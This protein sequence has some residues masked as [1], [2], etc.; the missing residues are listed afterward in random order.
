MDDEAAPDSPEE[1]TNPKAGKQEEA[2]ITAD[3]ITKIIVKK[4]K[5]N[6]SNNQ[7]IGQ[8]LKTYGVERVSDLPET[9]YEAF[10]T[11]LAAL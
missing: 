5:Q 4:I 7:R 10:V 11:D 3:D 6:R 9:K 2:S 1:T 8:L